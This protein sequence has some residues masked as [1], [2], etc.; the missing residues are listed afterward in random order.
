MADED[1][2]IDT[3]IER[4]LGPGERHVRGLGRIRVYV[5]NRLVDDVIVDRRAF[6]I[7]RSLD[8][9]LVLEDKAASRIHAQIATVRDTRDL[10]IQD[11]GSA[12]GT[13]VNGARI[14]KKLLEHND[15]IRIGDTILR[16]SRLG[17]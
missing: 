9:T 17:G 8:C 6:T 1:T 3:V 2:S 5:D 7:G 4:E 15:K 10:T 11:L 13:K 12:N 14:T 16:Y